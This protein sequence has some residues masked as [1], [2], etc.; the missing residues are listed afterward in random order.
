M[1]K[2][3][4][5]KIIHIENT[6][7]F[8]N[9]FLMDY[10]DI[11]YKNTNDVEVFFMKDL[12][13]KKENTELLGK[14]W[15]KYAMYSNVYSEKDEFDIF[16]DLFDYSIKNKK[17]IHI[18][19]ITLQKELNILEEYYEKLGFLRD[20]INCFRVDFSKVLVS[21]SV[22]IE[23]LMWRWSDYKRM[24]KK[25]FFIPPIREAGLTKAVFKW[26]NRWVIAWININLLDEEKKNF[27]RDCVINEHILPFNMQKVLRYNLEDVWFV[28]DVI[29]FELKYDEIKNNWIVY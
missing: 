20:D 12:L 2:I 3:H 26:I 8:D 27:L 5:N 19:W 28:W 10:L 9:T 11:D 21:V 13:Q 7:K 14:I 4:R 17:K 16:K 1:K 25:I 6:P 15:D 18:V 29:S 22:N 24:W 23:N